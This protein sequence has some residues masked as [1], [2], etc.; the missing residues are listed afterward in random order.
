MLVLTA[1]D[2]LDDRFA[3]DLVGLEGREGPVENGGLDRGRDT[4]N[5]ERPA[6]END[7]AALEQR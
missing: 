5:R 2:G 6:L 3:G 4:S 7:D 1:E